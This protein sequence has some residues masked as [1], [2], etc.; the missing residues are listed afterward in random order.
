MITLCMVHH[1][2]GKAIEAIR[3]T[4]AKD[5][6]DFHFVVG[7]GEGISGDD[8]KQFDVD[9]SYHGLIHKVAHAYKW[10]LEEYPDEQVFCKI[11]DDMWADLDALENQWKTLGKNDIH[12]HM[13][14]NLL[15]A[16]ACVMFSRRAVEWLVKCYFEEV[17]GWHPDDCSYMTALHARWHGKVV[18]AEDRWTTF[19]VQHG[20]NGSTTCIDSAIW[21]AHYRGV[22]SR[23]R[24]PLN[25]YAVGELTPEE[26]VFV[27]NCE[28]LDK[29]VEVVQANRQRC[30]SC[31]HARMGM[32]RYNMHDATMFSF[33]CYKKDGYVDLT[34]GGCPEG[35]HVS[36]K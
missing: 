4:W 30:M 15:M 6:K 17:I 2:A 23:N 12:G 16:G 25:V 31:P 35:R 21:L 28:N 34:V 24:Q 29:V 20:L 32:A 9:D 1:G 22:V 10:A 14:T 33:G 27:H 18:I 36:C 7:N 8:V 11:D 5:R 3:S 19:A 26:I 13:V